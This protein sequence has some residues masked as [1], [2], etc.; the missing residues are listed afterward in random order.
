MTRKITIMI[1]SYKIHQLRN[2][3][4]KYSFPRIMMIVIMLTIT[5]IIKWWSFTLLSPLLMIIIDNH[6]FVCLYYA[7]LSHLSPGPRRYRFRESTPHTPLSFQPT[8]LWWWKTTNNQKMMMICLCYPHKPVNTT[9]NLNIA[10]FSPL[11]NLP[12]SR[13]PPAF[14]ILCKFKMILVL[15]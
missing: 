10:K 4:S 11:S 3:L 13:Q 8:W 6:L 12:L 7:F 5:T 2:T 1:S 15:H 14:D 9:L